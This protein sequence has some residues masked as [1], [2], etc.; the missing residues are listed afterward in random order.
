MLSL[1]VLAGGNSSRMAQDKALLIFNGESLIQRVLRRL[2]GFANEVIVVTNHPWNFNNLG[3]RVVTDV[4]NERSSMT[5]LFTAMSVARFERVGVVAC[6]MPFANAQLLNACNVILAKSHA[7]AVVPRTKHGYEP[8]HAVYR[9]DAC[10][11][12]LEQTLKSNERRLG[13]W[14]RSLAVHD[15]M[16]EENSSYGGSEIIFCNVNTPE[17][18]KKAEAWAVSLET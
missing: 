10:L 17:E 5:G 18:F 15:V 7:D 16:V 3:V 6:D 2:S 9:R 8:L 13:L 14:L 4:L 11:P 12:K 1:V